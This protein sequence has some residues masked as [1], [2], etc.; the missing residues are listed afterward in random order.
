MFLITVVVASL[1]FVP[2]VKFARKTPLVNFYW[3]GFWVFLALIA[4]F[5]G[6]SN[7][8]MM[9]GIDDPVMSAAAINA[10]MSAYICFVVFA[11]F[12][13]SGTAFMSLA[14]RFVPVRVS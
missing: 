9:M 4:G 2:V 7:T 1:F 14:K 3:V 10:V 13:L 11:W 12:R 8:L 6:A 5:A